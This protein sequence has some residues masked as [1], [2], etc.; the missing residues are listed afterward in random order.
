MKI[1]SSRVVI[2]IALLVAS[3]FYLFPLYTA[4][5]TS[6]KSD[7]EMISGPV[8]PVKRPTLVNFIRAFSIIKR[9]MWNSVIITVFSTAFSSF[10][11]AMSG[12]G[13]SRL[14]FKGSN[15]LLLIIV[16]GFYIPPQAVLIP[17][18]RFMGKIGLYNTYAGLI[19]T[20]TAYGMPITTLL[21]KNY[22]DT[23]PVEVIESARI[24]GCSNIGAFFRVALPLSLPGFAV[25]AI[26]QFTN[27]WNE[28]LYGLIL[29]QGRES[30][31]LTV[32][33]A[34]LKGTTVASWNI[35]MAGVLISVFPVLITYLFFLRL[36]IKGLLMGS[37]KG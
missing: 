19:L 23:L 31:P 10:L 36:I 7:E 9:S 34:N 20:H 32:A 21:F 25:V 28:F 37:V 3:F 14:K 5:N 13:F 35:Q 26:F 12:F 17:L 24:D 29:T 2:Y 8:Q 6:L 11:G 15:L 18:V 4:V 33:I 16:L 22:F 27:I 1:P 30:Q